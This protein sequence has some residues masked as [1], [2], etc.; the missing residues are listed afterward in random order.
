MAADLWAVTPL[1]Q[2][3][4]EISIC[5]AERGDFAFALA[6]VCF[7]ATACDPYRFVAHFHPV[8]VKNLLVIA[9]LL[10]NTAEATAALGQAIESVTARAD[11]DQKAR[12]T[13]RDIDQ[14]ALC[15]M[16]LTMVLR[17]APPGHAHDWE[18]AATAREMLHDI[19][20]LPGR[21]RELS[22]IAAW[23]RD[24][25][26]DQSRAFFDYAVVQ[27]VDALAGLGL[28]VLQGQFGK[29]A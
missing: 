2:L 8:R 5:Y 25:A 22:L 11:L 12:E 1:P 4:T 17:S 7:V 10:A 21:D 16:L 19:A 24:P 13:L 15:Q 29:G 6:V 18:M 27:K 14:V 3:L 28:A 26:D 23:T 20:Q 9:K